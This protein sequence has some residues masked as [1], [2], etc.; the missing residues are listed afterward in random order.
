MERAYSK[1]S[2]RHAEICGLLCLDTRFFYVARRYHG[3]TTQHGALCD[4][5]SRSWGAT[6]S[7]GEDAVTTRI[8]ETDDFNRAN[9]NP[10]ASPWVNGVVLGS[11]Q[12]INNK[13]RGIVLSADQ[14]ARLNQINL[15]ADGFVQARLASATAN[16]GGVTFR[17]STT[18]DTFYLG[19][20]VPLS[21]P[22]GTRLSKVVDGV[23]TN[24]SNAAT[25]WIAN[26]VISLICVS[27]TI[28]I[29][30]NGITQS[31]VTDTAITP[32]GQAGLFIFSN[33][34]G[35][36]LDDFQAGDFGDTTDYTQFPKPNIAEAAARGE[37]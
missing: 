33:D 32:A 22:S 35:F 18:A 37:M 36:E 11:L 9:E 27:T 14:T 23:L 26:D 34:A 16:D 13:V 1:Q 24:L 21:A 8:R 19:G 17:H 28:T 4:H 20:A 3:N 25:T 10:I 30:Q 31:T 2:R 29:Q 6:F 7:Y 5:H 15:P 12:L